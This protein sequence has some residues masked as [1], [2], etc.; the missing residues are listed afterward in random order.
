MG[1]DLHFIY[2]DSYDRDYRRR[3]A[4]YKQTSHPL[5]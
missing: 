3:S 1:K 4:H 2:E 5:G